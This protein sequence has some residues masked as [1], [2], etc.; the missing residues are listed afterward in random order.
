MHKV[1]QGV[2]ENDLFQCVKDIITDR[3]KRGGEGGR[4]SGPTPLDP[5]HLI[6]VYRQTLFLTLVSLGQD[7]IHLTA[8]GRLADLSE[9]IFSNH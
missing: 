2:R 4:D 6:S 7:N 5:A 9:I 8:F 3:V 1:I